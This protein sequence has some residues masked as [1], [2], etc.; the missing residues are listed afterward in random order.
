M[1]TRGAKFVTHPAGTNELEFIFQEVI[2]SKRIRNLVLRHV[3]KALA[4]ILLPLQLVIALLGTYD[5]VELSKL[6]NLVHH[7]VH[8]VQEHG[9]QDLSFLN[10]LVEHFGTDSINDSE[11]ESLP[12]L[13]GGG[14]QIPAVELPTR[15]ILAALS[16]TD[17]PSSAVERPVSAPLSAPADIFQPPRQ[18]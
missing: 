3:M 4:T 15:M 8:H 1:V 7:Y 5:P 16:P 13:G 18:S 11:H 2:H 10:F 6:G 17:A 9:E 14:W 12:L